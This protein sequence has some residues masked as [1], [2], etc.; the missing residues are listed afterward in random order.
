[1][2]VAERKAS[3][4]EQVKLVEDEQILRMIEAVLKVHLEPTDE[5][6]TTT[7][8]IS[9]QNEPTDNEDLLGYRADGSPVYAKE[10]KLIYDKQIEEMKRGNFHTV[11]EVRELRK[12]W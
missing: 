8:E 5:S 1:M 9:N 7:E 4:V 2:L 12:T 11:D 6:L 10:A 3:I